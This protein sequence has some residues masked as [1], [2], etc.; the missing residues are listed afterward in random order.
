[1]T[2]YTVVL[3]I[4]DSNDEIK[5]AIDIGAKTKNGYGKRMDDGKDN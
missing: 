5:N 3:E 1:M 4:L 2:I